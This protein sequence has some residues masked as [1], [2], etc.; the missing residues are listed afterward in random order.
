[1]E[2]NRQGNL[3]ALTLTFDL[4][5]TSQSQVHMWP[6]TFYL[7]L[8]GRRP[9]APGAEAVYVWPNVLP[10]YDQ[11]SGKP[12]SGSREPKKSDLSHFA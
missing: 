4:I 3:S 10:H 5:S 7:Y 8:R 11:R 9:K 6:F 1:M 2:L 12:L